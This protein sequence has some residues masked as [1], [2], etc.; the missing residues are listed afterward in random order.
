[1]TS[2]KNYCSKK[3]FNFPILSDPE[4]KITAKFK[5]QKEGGKGVLRTVYALDTEGN[6]IHAERGMGD[7]DAIVNKI[8]SAG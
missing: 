3:G 5:S 7:F 6:V 2:H 4:G 8:K 1:M